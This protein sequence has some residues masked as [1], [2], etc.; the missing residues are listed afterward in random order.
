MMRLVIRSYALLVYALFL[1]TFTY[2]ILFVAGWGVP[3][4]VDAGPATAPLDAAAI[5]VGL[6][7]FF[8][9]LHSVMARARFKR[10]WTKIVPPAAERSTYVLV[11]S[12]QLALLCWQWRPLVAPQLF[13]ASGALAASLRALQATGWAIVLLSTVLI[14]HLEL[15]GLRQ[16]FGREA[17]APSFRTPLLYRWVRHPLYFGLLLAFWSAP[18]MT[19]GHLLLSASLTGYLLIGVRHEERDLVRTFGETYRRYQAEVP[20]LLPFPRRLRAKP[21]VGESVSS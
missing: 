13:A 5:D 20:M 18:T 2:F 1:L 9:L 14:D 16:G 7:A 17:T 10:I 3:R 11:A 21:L 12:A 15:F 4:T 8:G 19:A 6:V